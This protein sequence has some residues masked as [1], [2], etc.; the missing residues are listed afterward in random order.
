[1][2][3]QHSDHSGNDFSTAC[4][5]KETHDHDHGHAASNKLFIVLIITA[6]F[7]LVEFIAGFWS[8]SLA[9][10]ADA[11]HM[12]TDSA[13]LILALGAAWFSRRPPTDQKTFGYLRAEILAALFNGLLLAVLSGGLLWEAWQRFAVAEGIHVPTMATVSFLGLL[14]NLVGAWILHGSRKHNLNLRGAYLHVLSD[15]LTSLG[16]LISAGLIAWTGYLYFDPL[17]SALIA[18]AVLFSAW[19]LIRE[20]IHIILQGSPS[21][22]ELEKIRN[23]LMAI[24]GV[25]GLHNLH[26]WSLSHSNTIL[27]VHIESDGRDTG[28]LLKE[29]VQI[30]KSEFALNHSTV[31]IETSE[32]T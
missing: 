19:R 32:V 4:L 23:R 9:L 14:I 30:L 10:I 22:I 16:A 28:A 2:G 7:M 27:T 6:S 29:I 8:N 11:V 20:T 15:A 26:V 17:V 21:N 3:L 5:K 25:R 24:P 31:Q 18:A 12:L 13:S 1:M